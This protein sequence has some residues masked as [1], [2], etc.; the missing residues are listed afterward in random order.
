MPTTD[1]AEV[2]VEAMRL[3]NGYALAVDTRDWNYFSTLFAPD[4]IAH[5]PNTTYEGMQD[6]LDSFIPF[7]DQC[8]WTLHVMTNHL[9]GTDDHGIWGTCY[10]WVQWTHE[11]TPGRINRATVLYRD[12]LTN[13]DGTW[14]IA[15][16]KLDLLL[17]EAPA[18]IPAGVTMSSSVLDLADRS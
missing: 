13:R 8:G 6:W 10:G 1:L 3:Q 2:S 17:H 5:Y 16:R 11:D 15:R 7:H 14:H 18:P 12:R 4:V 9:V